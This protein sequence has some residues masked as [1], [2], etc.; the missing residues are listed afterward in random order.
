VIEADALELERGGARIVAGVTLRVDGGEVVGIVGPNGAGKSSLLALLA[1]DIVP[2]RGSVR[3]GGKDLR[4]TREIDLAKRRAVM[5]QST[6][7]AFAF[8]A[9]EIVLMG[10]SP[11]GTRE[12]LRDCEVAQQALAALDLAP[13][14]QRTYPTL[15]GG[16]QQRV[17]LARVL[18][19]VELGKV[20]EALLLDEPT[21]SLDP[22]HQHQAM[23]QARAVATS[24]LAVVVVLHD[25]NLAAQYCDRVA[26]MKEGQLARID[27]PRAALSEELLASVFG[28][29]AHVAR[30]PWDPDKPWIA[31]RPR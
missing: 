17:Q 18:A 26:V 7:V 23:E 5:S 20:G 21:S 8:T 29:E 4:S 14:A 31:F 15:S 16:E 1:G 30:A 19:Q 13:F 2:T 27:S 10:R 24:G 22:A 25:L 11:F 6:S 12:S 3:L 28:A 9:L